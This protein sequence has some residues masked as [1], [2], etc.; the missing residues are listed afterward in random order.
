[1]RSSVEVSMIHLEMAEKHELKRVRLQIHLCMSARTQSLHISTRVQ[2]RTLVM[3][4]LGLVPL[5]AADFVC[6]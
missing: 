4:T 6:L 1:M 5:H 3:H 2:T